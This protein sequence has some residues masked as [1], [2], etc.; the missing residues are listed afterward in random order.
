[1]SVFNLNANHMNKLTVLATAMLVAL[2]VSTAHAQ[3]NPGAWYWGINGSV[4][5]TRDAA[6]NTNTEFSIAP[7]FGYKVND[8][9]SVGGQLGYNSNV[10]GDNNMLFIAPNAR[11]YYRYNDNTFL[12][13]QGSVAAGWGSER[14]GDDTDGYDSDVF[15]LETGIRPGILF[16]V[17]DRVGIEFQYGFLGYRQ[18]T[19][20]TDGGDDVTTSEAGL[21]LNMNGR[22]LQDLVPITFSGPTLGIHF[23]LGRTSE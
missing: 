11:W 14:F 2:T 21:Q 1:M 12:Y 8:G 17:S 5:S 7:S 4:W 18:W 10:G 9:W 22:Q 20:S 23:W 16:F 3:L 6:D 13:F 19:Y 15:A